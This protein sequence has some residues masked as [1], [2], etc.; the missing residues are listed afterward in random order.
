MMAFEFDQTFWSKF[1]ETSRAAV[2]I[3]FVPHDGAEIGPSGSGSQNF[4]IVIGEYEATVELDSHDIATTHDSSGTLT[5][6]GIHTL[7]VLA[8]N[9]DEGQ[10]PN[11]TL[12]IDAGVSIDVLAVRVV[13]VPMP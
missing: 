6:S 3:V 1:S 13:P 7:T 8:E 9:L 11:V 12:E 10:S 4:R 2:K 5:D